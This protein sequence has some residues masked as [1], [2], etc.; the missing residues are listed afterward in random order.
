MKDSDEKFVTWDR[1]ERIR[2][3]IGGIYV[4]NHQSEVSWD[5]GV[6]PGG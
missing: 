1:E 3:A 6:G 4:R 2:P 5:A